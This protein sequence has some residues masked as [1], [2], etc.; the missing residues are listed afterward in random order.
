M[1]TAVTNF[2]FIVGWTVA[3]KFVVYTC[4]ITC[5]CGMSKNT[6]RKPFGIGM[7]IG[8][9]LGGMCCSGS[10]DTSLG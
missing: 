1:L 4:G 6:G 9:V 3:A 10:E 5:G 2:P 7:N 8:G